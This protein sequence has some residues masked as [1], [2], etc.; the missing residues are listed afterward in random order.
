MRRKTRFYSEM[1]AGMA[2]EPANSRPAF[3]KRPEWAYGTTPAAGH[4]FRGACVAGRRRADARIGLACSEMR[5]ITGRPILADR[6]DEIDKGAQLGTVGPGPRAARPTER[7]FVAW[8]FQN[9]VP[10]TL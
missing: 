2:F 8:R 5:D 9:S 10:R 6:L 4:R 7:S 1:R 3:E